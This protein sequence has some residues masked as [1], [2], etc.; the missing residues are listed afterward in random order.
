MAGRPPKTLTDKQRDEVE[1]LAPFL[2]I[3]QIADYFGMSKPTF[4]SIMERDDDISLRYKR[5]RA[6]VVADIS[7]S[8][9]MKAREGDNACMFFYLKTQAGW[10]ETEKVEI[11]GPNGGPI[12]TK[13][14]ATLSPE[15]AYRK[16]LGKDGA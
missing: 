2:S 13:M 6:K 10:R 12:Q 5:G 4:Y 7:N 9:I 3:E 8:L 1:T 15:D 16:M 14:D 11:S